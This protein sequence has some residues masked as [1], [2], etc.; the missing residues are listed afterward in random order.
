MP[1]ADF[2]YSQQSNPLS[3]QLLSQ[4]AQVQTYPTGTTLSSIDGLPI[5]KRKRGRP[6]KSRTIE[7]RL[8]L[9]GEQRKRRFSATK[10]LLRFSI[11]L[12]LPPQIPQSVSSS[13][14]LSRY[15]S[16]QPPMHQMP[17]LAISQLSLAA[18]AAA[19]YGNPNLP[20]PMPNPSHFASGVPNDESLKLIP[21]PL[22]PQ[23]KPE[24]E[25]GFYIFNEGSP[26]PDAL[27]IYFA[28]RHY[29]CSQPRCYYVTNREDILVLHSKDF[30]DN[31]DIYE[32]FVFF[33]RS[34]DCR[35]PGCPSNK[36]NRHFHCTRLGCNYTFVRYSTMTAHEEK[37]RQEANDLSSNAS[38]ASYN[39]EPMP[40]QH[41]SNN[42]AMST[43]ASQDSS[44]SDDDSR[45]AKSPFNA[46]SC[47]SPSTHSNSSQQ[48]VNLSTQR[49][50]AVATFYPLSGFTHTKKFNGQ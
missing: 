22:L 25:E 3:D 39:D 47:G 50:K 35:M 36:T 48:A 16:P 18:A 2:D 23:A 1:S 14:K 9:I 43:T 26:C 12:S 24:T 41:N 40:Y 21:V 32:G 30:H 49:I 44:N 4:S 38:N 17:T 37:H 27:C 11:D 28:Q 31:I 7:V 46:A 20:L 8:S 19:L 6:P 5:L 29:H 33:D 45:S 34:V 15:D 42:G 10:K 13:F